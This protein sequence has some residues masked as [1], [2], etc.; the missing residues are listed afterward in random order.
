MDK[1]NR[2]YM[3]NLLNKI[4]Y[5]SISLKKNLLNEGFSCPSCGNVEAEH[6]SRKFLITSLKRC[7]KC[8]LMFRVPTGT[9]DENKSFYSEKESYKQGFGTDCPSDEILNKYIKLGFKGTGRDYSDYK[10]VISV[11]NKNNKSKLFDYGC[12]WGYG[13][14]QLKQLGLEV[15]SYEISKSRSTYAKNKLGINIINDLNLLKKK[16]YDFFFSAHVLEHLPNVHELIKFSFEI[17]KKNGF[18]LGFTPN[19]SLKNKLKNK[20]WN[21]WWG[22][23]HPNFLDDI[24]Y[25]NYFSNS[26]FFIAS[27]PYNLSHLNEWLENDES[28]CDELDGEELMIVV[29]KTDQAF[30]RT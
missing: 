14:Y 26:K 21:K 23:V 5:F 17:I 13:S 12:S 1:E 11:I 20:N 24:F 29:K 19:G 2:L 22:M 7:K 30:L 8:K 28:F 10:K 6:I 25:K 9:V 3:D 18:F 27:L 4:N 15:D 16:S